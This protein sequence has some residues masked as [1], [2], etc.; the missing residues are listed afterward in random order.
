[1][2]TS[3]SAADLIAEH[4]LELPEASQLEFAAA[5]E[6]LAEQWPL[7]SLS[8][9][10]ESGEDE[11]W[12]V[13]RPLRRLGFDRWAA[14]G[15]RVVFFHRSGGWCLKAP[16]GCGF[17]LATRREL[18]MLDVMDAADRELF[19][20]TI[21][22]PG[23]ILLQRVYRVDAARFDACQRASREITLAARRLGVPDVNPVNVGWTDDGA[24]RFI[25]W[26][27][28]CRRVM[29]FEPEW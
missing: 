5:A 26:A 10:F 16:R 9:F 12:P 29:Y 4:A 22:L 27:G 15:E 28:L 23:D 17:E 6:M 20:H 3:P 2:H 19:A 14:G 18:A 13:P 8:I 24:W 7:G 1:M 11:T 21:A 25:D